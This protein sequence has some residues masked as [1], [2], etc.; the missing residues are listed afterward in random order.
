MLKKIQIPPGINKESTQYAAAGSWYDANNV[1]FRRG[2]AEVIGGWSRDGTYELQGFGRACFSSRDY[3]GNNYQFAGTDWKYYVITGTA[4]FDITP[5][6]DSGTIGSTPFTAIKGNPEIL[7]SHASH[8]LSVNDWVV[9]TSVPSGGGGITTDQLEQSHGFQVS[10]VVNSDVYRFYLVDWDTGD[11]VKPSVAAVGFGGT[12]AYSYKITSGVSTQVLGQAWGAGLWGGDAV[13]TVYGLSVSSS[14]GEQGVT[15]TDDTTAQVQF[16]FLTSS[17]PSVDTASS[18]YFTELSGSVGE[19]LL[20]TLNNKWWNVVSIGSSGLYSTFKIVAPV[21]PEDTGSVI[22]TTDNNEF[23]F[24]ALDDGETVTGAD[25]GWGDSSTDTIETGTIRRVYID[26][27]GEDIMI[28]NSGGPIYYWDVSA[29]TSVGVPIGTEGAVAKLLN[30]FDGESGS[31]TIVDSFLISKKDGHCVALGCNDIGG[32]ELNSVLVRWSDQNNPF[33]WT[34]SPTNTSG[35]QVL[36]VGSRILG[37]LSTKD[38]VVIFTDAAVYS[39]RFVGPPDVFAFNLITEGVEIVGSMAA[40]NAAN[41]VYFMGNDGFYVYTGA[42]SPLPSTVAN[43]VFDDFNSSQRHKCFAAVNSAFSEVIWFYPSADA[44][45]PDRYAMFNYDDGVWSIGSFDMTE[46]TDSETKTNPYSRTSWRDAIVFANPMSTYITD[47]AP[48]TT[49]QN[50]DFVSGDDYAVPMVKNSAVM[51]HESGT[52]AQNSSIDAYIESGEV[53]ISDGER[54]SFYSRILP[55]LQVFNASSETAKVTI[56]LNGR[57]FPGSAAAQETSTDV[58][59]TVVSPN[60]SSTYTPVQNATAIRGRARS[61]SMRVASSSTDFQWRL[62][63]TRIDL[64]PDG[65][66]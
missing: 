12:V 5:V 25:R 53:D 1:R 17:G 62:G 19:L 42:V 47:Y 66:R 43:Y 40:A 46:F 38:E 58:D 30:T 16:A 22:L 4:A 50:V 33:E 44:F 8:G 2:N 37:G 27:Y 63:D 54:F 18:V 24:A 29:S 36:R 57:E 64:R 52:K 9:F 20:T 28:A 35:G 34:P 26:N 59:F 48:S 32:A 65:R 15:G 11:V 45:E 56:S 21:D 60:S 7:V 55:D 3:E 23:Y 10:T 6:R 31:P 13:P 51:I 14:A 41:A 61:V 49:A 39:M